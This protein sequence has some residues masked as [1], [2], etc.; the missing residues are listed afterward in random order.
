M[1]SAERRRFPRIAD[2]GL[3]LNLKSDNFDTVTHTLN[4]SASGVYCKIDKEL[5]LM[6]RVNL[7]LMIPDV[8]EGAKDTKT[9]TVSGVVVREHP[10]IING[11]TKHYDVAIFFDD[12]SKADRDIISAYINQDEKGPVRE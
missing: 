10:V 12:L 2:E 3:S 11:Q 5:P 1:V 9:I 6:S 7:R 8:G 4:I